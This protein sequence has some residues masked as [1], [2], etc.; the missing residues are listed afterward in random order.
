MLIWFCLLPSTTNGPS[1][2][3]IPPHSVSSAETGTE[4]WQLPAIQHIVLGPFS[5]KTMHLTVFARK[6]STAVN[7]TPPLTPDLFPTPSSKNQK[8]QRHASQN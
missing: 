3:L 2:W 7:E 5:Q 8:K 4:K 6:N 1:S